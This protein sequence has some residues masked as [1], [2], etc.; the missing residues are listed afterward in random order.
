MGRPRLSPL[1]DPQSLVVYGA[2]E[3]PHCAGRLLLEG[4]T[5]G[6]FRGRYRVVHPTR[7]SVL[8]MACVPSAAALDFVPDVALLAS[9][10]ID[11][12]RVMEDCAARGTRFLVMFDHGLNTT[13]DDHPRLRSELIAKLDG[14]EKHFV[15]VVLKKD[16]CV[17]DFLRIAPVSQRSTA[18][19][20][21]FVGGFHA[22]KPGAP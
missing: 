17:W 8:G 12:M 3:T 9:G 10:E 4:L 7:D 6:G 18:G 22:M 21:R 11:P 16:G 14:V 20:D 2:S 5:Q 19:F 13:L 15:V 1:F